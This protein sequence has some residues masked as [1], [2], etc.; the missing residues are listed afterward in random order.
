M[1]L[2]PF[3]IAAAAAVAGSAGW[4]LSREDARAAGFLPYDDP[5]AIAEG[6]EIYREYCA[7]CHG[8]D[9]EGQPN[10]RQRD[11]DG[12]LPAPPHDMTGHTWHHPDRQL[13]LITKLGTE[14]IV[15]NGYR[16]R[17]AGFGDVLGDQDI[18]NVLAYIKSTWPAPVIER[19]N[20][21]NAQAAQE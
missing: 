10:W 17:M 11:E 5:A 14:A 16:S 8:G 1:K 4:L 19:H 9:L 12:Y 2:V 20:M 7:A 18:V 13:F 21:R 3:V 15:G 6:R